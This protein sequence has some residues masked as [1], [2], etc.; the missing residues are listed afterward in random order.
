MDGRVVPRGEREF[1]LPFLL[2]T[3]TRPMARK[4]DSGKIPPSAT[5]GA[6]GYGNDHEPMGNRAD[7][8]RARKIPAALP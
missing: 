4:G 7:A 8:R 3:P 6:A 5:N 1:A 2:F